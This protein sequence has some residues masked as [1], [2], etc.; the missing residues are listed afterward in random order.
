VTPNYSCWSGIALRVRIVRSFLQVSILLKLR[1]NIHEKVAF[2]ICWVKH[3]PTPNYLTFTKCLMWTPT[4][5]HTT[6]T[7]VVW[8]EIGIRVWRCEGCEGFFS[9]R[10]CWN[11]WKIYMK[12]LPNNICWCGTNLHLHTFTPFTRPYFLR[13]S[14]VRFVRFLRHLTI[15]VGL[16]L[17]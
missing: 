14:S 6:F 1:K 8:V 2:Y 5:L 7:L 12:K 15:D 4:Y 11:L 9:S 16:E 3:Y 10:Y 13:V 17:V